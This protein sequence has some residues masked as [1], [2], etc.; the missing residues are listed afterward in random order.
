MRKSTTRNRHVYKY[1]SLYTCRYIHVSL[2]PS[3][4]EI[5][6]EDL[7]QI[8]RVQTSM[9]YEQLWWPTGCEQAPPAF[10]K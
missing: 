10:G 8:V 4:C 3:Q 2:Y 9:G 7:I 1:V 5:S 6:E